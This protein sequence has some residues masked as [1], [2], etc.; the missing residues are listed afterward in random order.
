M[1]AVGPRFRAGVIEGFYGRPWDQAERHRLLGWLE[2]WGLNTYL[3]A[4]KDDLHHRA[5]WRE[6]YDGSAEH[7]LRELIEACRARGVALVYGIAPG[8]DIRYDE[9]EEVDRMCG[10]FGQLM[11]AGCVEFA[12][13]F[14]DIP[15]SIDD[16]ALARWG[17][18]AGAQSH[19]ANAVFRWT[20]E[21][22]PDARFLFCPTP[23]CGR[24]AAAEVGG[25][26]YLETIGRELDEA[27][28]VFWTGPD[29]VSR[30]ISVEHVR[31]VRA[32]LRRK[33]T[34][35][36]NLHAN[37]YD[38]TRMFCGPYAGRPRQLLDEVA[39]LL[40]NPNVELP[41]NYV[42]LRTLAWFVD[43]QRA[44]DERDAYLAAMEEWRP[45]FDTVRGATA[46]ADLVQFGDCFYLPWYEGEEGEALI[47]SAGRLVRAAMPKDGASDYLERSGRLRAFC[48]AV[49]ELRD[50][51]LFH[52]INR[53]V[54]A[55]RE[56]LDLF[57][58]FAGHVGEG[59]T[60]SD[61]HLPGTYRGG[62]VARLQRLLVQ[63]PDG[64]FEPAGD[65]GASDVPA[66]RIRE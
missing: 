60:T 16:R 40:S 39:G 20:R 25:A 61:F 30:E 42:P 8:L 56:E 1:T 24:M 15:G 44:W 12:L 62:I 51:P 3:Y 19:V 10:R 23:Y 13:L 63:M 52:A 28:E 29:I 41:L 33:P 65:A 58:R 32:V 43:G 59:P 47:R 21:Q 22:H 53:R 64:T 49:T 54:W 34:I 2:A 27:I 36:D 57:D 37:D 31:G 38:G 17:S 66:D 6:P 45:A 9:P 7:S 46:L 55:L 50:R 35:W 14:D 48:A 26:G 11:R 5:V 18:L 4:P